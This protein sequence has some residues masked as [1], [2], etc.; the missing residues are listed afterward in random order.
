[1]E[2]EVELRPCPWCRQTPDIYMPIEEETWIWEI[3]CKNILCT[4]KPR[5]P[6]ISIRKTSKIYL[7][8]LFLKLCDLA[9]KWNHGNPFPAFEAKSIDLTPIMQEDWI[10]QFDINKNFSRIKAVN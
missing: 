7:I 10:R 8:R 2:I 3:K 6:H 4:M 5:S 9:E 1:M